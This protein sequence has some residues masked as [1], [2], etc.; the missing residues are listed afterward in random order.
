MVICAQHHGHYFEMTVRKLLTFNMYTDMYFLLL[1]FGYKIIL[2]FCEFGNHGIL[3]LNMEIGCLS[4]ITFGTSGLY[5]IEH[6]KHK[7]I[8]CINK[9]SLRSSPVLN[10][11]QLHLDDYVL[12]SVLSRYSLLFHQISTFPS[13]DTLTPHPEP[14]HAHIS[15]LHTIHATKL[16]VHPQLH[17]IMP[18]LILP[19]S[20]TSTSA[21]HIQYLPNQLLHPAS[22]CALDQHHHTCKFTVQEQKRTHTTLIDIDKHILIY[23]KISTV[24]A[25]C[26]DM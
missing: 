12:S 13:C 20:Q 8:M 7:Q 9:C 2:M 24:Y 1:F 23:F 14:P 22:Y 11:P 10:P 6:W 19:V 18:P 5:I 26:S 3:N 4:Y 25:T 16:P 17:P 15:T 21:F